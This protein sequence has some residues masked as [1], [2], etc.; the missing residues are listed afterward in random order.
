MAIS[1]S[2]CTMENVTKF[3]FFPLI[4]GSR[5]ILFACLRA[6]QENKPPARDP[7]A[8]EFANRLGFLGR[9]GT[10]P[11]ANAARYGNTLSLEGG[12]VESINQRPAI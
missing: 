2:A 8:N 4:T 7:P 11:G 6:G 9:L 10:K 5:R 12:S 3:N 1:K